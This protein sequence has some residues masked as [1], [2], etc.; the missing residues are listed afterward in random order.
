MQSRLGRALE[1]RRDYVCIILVAYE[2]DKDYPLIVAANRDEVF[3]RPS[4]GAHYWNDVEGVFAGR[5]LQA[6]GTWLGVSRKGRF[7]GVTNWAKSDDVSDDYRSRGELV[8]DFLVSLKSASDFVE[9]IDGPRYRGFN[10]LVYDGA[11]L[12]YW[13][14]RDDLFEVFSPGYYGITNTSF[15][16]KWN[17]TRVGVDMIS[18]VRH[19]H[20]VDSLLHLLRRHSGSSYDPSDVSHTS[21]SVASPC[22]VLGKTYGTRASTAVV[23]R[24]ESILF[25][26][27]IYGPQA[28]PKTSVYEEIGLTT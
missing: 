18:K 7:A 28:V 24:K 9:S 22:F 2:V 25:K 19:L 10:L 13:S 12:V 5:D 1:Q 26:E 6:D 15:S 23:F 21:M 27:Q 3:S 8:R 4:L 11:E 20:D 17:K 14:N 16:N